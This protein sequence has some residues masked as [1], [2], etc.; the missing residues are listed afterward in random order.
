MFRMIVIPFLMV[1]ILACGS[2]PAAT[3][4]PVSV[5]HDLKATEWSKRDPDAPLFPASARRAQIVITG[6]WSADDRLIWVVSDRT[7]LRVV[8]WTRNGIELQAALALISR[9]TESNGF[10]SLFQPILAHGG[11]AVIGHGPGGPPPPPGI[12][13]KLAQ[14]VLSF[15]AHED[16][17]IIQLGSELPRAGGVQAQ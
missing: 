5:P 6:G 10:Q 7:E 8:Y 11:G 13:P 9:A 17:Q 2:K 15:V 16:D 4:V 1:G 12:P 14:V 3:T